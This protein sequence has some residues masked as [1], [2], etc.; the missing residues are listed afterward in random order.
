MMT[1]LERESV[2]R[3]FPQMH[4]DDEEDCNWYRAS[5]DMYCLHCGL[6]Y[7]HHPVEEFFNID[8]RLCNG[9]IVHL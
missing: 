5:G 3:L 8:H 4:Q 6:Q 1:R 2:L 7:R 9:E